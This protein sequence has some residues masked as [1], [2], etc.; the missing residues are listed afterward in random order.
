MSKPTLIRDIN[1]NL[2][3]SKE[4]TSKPGRQW[5]DAWKIDGNVISIEMAAARRTFEKALQD[6]A[7]A[8]MRDDLT[9]AWVKASMKGDAAK[10]AALR[11]E[12]NAIEALTSSPILKSAT[13][14]QELVALWDE[15]LL[16]P[17]PFL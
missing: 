4:I 1:G 3:D 12:M 13:S 17:N 6:A 16:G 7:R 5:R 8:R 15:A 11:D 10:V 9:P 14:P 2:R